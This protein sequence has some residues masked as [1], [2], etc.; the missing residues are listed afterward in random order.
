MPAP[1]GKQWIRLYRGLFDATPKSVDTK[2]LGV[3]WT[4]DVN[5]AYNFATNRNAEGDS[6]W[7]EDEIGDGPRGTVV[8]ALVH[9]RHVIDPNSEEGH[10]WL[11][12]GDIFGPEHPEQERTIRPGGTIHIQKMHNIDESYGDTP[13][14]ETTVFPRSIKSRGRA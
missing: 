1:N 11:M 8:E 4:P 9:R 3:H 5:V 12:G 6:Y 10:S 2:Q 13:D 7:T 14:I